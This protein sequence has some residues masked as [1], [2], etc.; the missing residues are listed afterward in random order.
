MSHPIPRRF[1]AIDLLDPLQRRGPQNGAPVRA[2]TWAA[3][4]AAAWVA[5]GLR[6]PAAPCSLHFAALPEDPGLSW[7]VTL[8]LPA[9]AHLLYCWASVVGA[10]P[11]SGLVTFRATSSY[12][13]EEVEWL[14]AAAPADVDL[15]LQ[16]ADPST[17][18]EQPAEVS[19]TLELVAEHE[20]CAAVAALGYFLLP[21]CDPWGPGSL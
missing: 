18:Q 19:V 17:A 14:Q 5:V 21:L 4:E 9:R 13:T 16:V 12:G 11:A 15:V 6:V 10:G 20:D 3:L 2:D 7:Q 8:R 1:P